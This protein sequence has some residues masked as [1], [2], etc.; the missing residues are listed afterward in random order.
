MI[1]FEHSKDLPSFY[2][3]GDAYLFI[4]QLFFKKRP[5]H[6]DKSKPEHFEPIRLLRPSYSSRIPRVSRNTSP[7][8]I[9]NNEGLPSV[10]HRT[11]LGSRLQTCWYHLCSVSPR[12]NINISNEIAISA[13]T[14]KAQD[15]KNCDEQALGSRRCRNLSNPAAY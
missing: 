9:M 10:Y 7:H 3:E 14:S 11:L 5:S 1:M 8:R 12:M 2:A 4:S 15:A 6:L 13:G